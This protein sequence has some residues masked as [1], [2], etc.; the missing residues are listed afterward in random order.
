MGRSLLGGMIRLPIEMAGTASKA[1]FAVGGRFTA[2]E[3]R[4]AL[5]KRRLAVALDMV[6]GRSWFAGAGSLGVG[7]RSATENQK[8]LKTLGLGLWGRVLGRNTF[9]LCEITFW[10]VSVAECPLPPGETCS[11]ACGHCDSRPISRVVMVW[12]GWRL[13]R[14]LSAYWAMFLG[15]WRVAG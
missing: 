8:L 14:R 7:K 11:E 4:F 12:T 1:R 10:C 2:R 13:A 15:G 5:E 9:Q 3:A 6:L